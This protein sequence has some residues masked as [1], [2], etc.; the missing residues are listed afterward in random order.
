MIFSFSFSDLSHNDGVSAC[1][2]HDADGNEQADNRVV[3]IDGADGHLSD[4]ALNEETV[5]HL[6]YGDKNESENT[7]C[8]KFQQ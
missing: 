5:N 1:A 8:Y 2:D 3:E 6:V 4:I 7:G